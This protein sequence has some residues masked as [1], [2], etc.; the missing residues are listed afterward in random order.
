V[1]DNIRQSSLARKAGRGLRRA[2]GALFGEKRLARAEES[3]DVLKQEY[4]A[5]REE[6]AA[7]DDA[8]PRRI[9]HRERPE[10]GD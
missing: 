10:S 9:A 7:D 1:S 6:G 3:L 8:T 4:R 2:L 5:G